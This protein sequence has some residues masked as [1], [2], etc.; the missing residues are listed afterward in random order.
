MGRATCNAQN[1]NADGLCKTE[2]RSDRERI[3]RD[4]GIMIRQERLDSG[5]EGRKDGR[6]AS[7]A[8][9]TEG[10]NASAT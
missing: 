5:W 3:D 10:R 7:C 2:L 4:A 6:K 8:R 1:E 9:L